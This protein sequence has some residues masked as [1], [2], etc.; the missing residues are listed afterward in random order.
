LLT[1]FSDFPGVAVNPTEAVVRALHGQPIAAVAVQGLVLPVAHPHAAQAL[2]D[3][4]LDPTTDLVL[5][6]GVAVTADRLRV[7]RQAVNL[8]DF[9]VPDATGQQPRGEPAHDQLPPGGVLRTRFATEPVVQRLQDAQ[10]PTESSDDAGRYVCNATYLWAL[11]AANRALF[12]HVPLLGTLDPQGQ[13]WTH[14]RLIQAVRL[15]LAELAMQG[16][17]DHLCT[18][19]G[20][21]TPPALTNRTCPCNPNGSPS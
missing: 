17:T 3:Q 18:G 6:L 16:S 15:V 5:L 14:D 12:L 20:S 10:L 13:A 1:G 8:L 7:E 11:A 4:G 19:A 9:R 21:A 2:Q